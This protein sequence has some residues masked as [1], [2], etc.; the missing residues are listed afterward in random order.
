[1]PYFLIFS[2]LCCDLHLSN[3]THITFWQASRSLPIIHQDYCFILNQQGAF[4]QFPS[5]DTAFISGADKG[6]RW[7]HYDLYVMVDYSPSYMLSTNVSVAVSKVDGSHWAWNAVCFFPRSSSRLF[8]ESAAGSPGMWSGG[9]CRSSFFL[10]LPRLSCLSQGA[11]R[12]PG[13]M[14]ALYGAGK[15]QNNPTFSS[16]TACLCVRGATK[17]LA[18]KRNAVCACQAA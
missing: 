10:F 6:N 7:L 4:I 13:C 8:G 1:M 11:S 9:K 16:N 14:D 12:R 15:S 18:L 5:A 3:A 2:S 17:G